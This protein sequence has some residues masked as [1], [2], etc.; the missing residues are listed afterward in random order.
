M[1]VIDA[2]EQDLESGILRLLVD[3]GRIGNV[4]VITPEYGN[5]KAS[6]QRAEAAA[7]RYLAAVGS[8]RADGLVWTQRVPPAAVAGFSGDGAGDRGFAHRP[9]GEKAVA[10]DAGLRKQ[11]AHLLGENRFILGVAGM[12]KNEHIFAWQTVLGDPVSSLQAHA[13]SWEIP[14]HRIHQSL[15]LDAVYAEVLSYSASKWSSCGKHRS[16][17]VDGGDPKIFVTLTRKMAATPDGR[18][19][20][21]GDQPVR[22][23]RRSSVFARRGEAGERAGSI[24]GCP[25]IGMTEV[26]GWIRPFSARQA[27]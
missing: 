22:A 10:G 24:T 3:F 4:G 9:G 11:R 23:L 27:G 18:R 19:R 16:V 21:Q 1:V 12:T 25:A 6:H 15:Q 26:S 14:F 8:R 2:P 20:G 5:P 7:G 17:M 13:L